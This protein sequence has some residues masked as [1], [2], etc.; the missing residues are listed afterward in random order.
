M[1]IPPIR[2]NHAFI[3]SALTN[4]QRLEVCNSLLIVHIQLKYLPRQ[5]VRTSPA[6]QFNWVQT[7]CVTCF[8]L[9]YISNTTF[10]D[11]VATVI[12]YV[13]LPGSNRIQINMESF[14]CMKKHGICY[15]F[16]CHNRTVQCWCLPAAQQQ[17]HVQHIVTIVK[18][19]MINITF[20]FIGLEWQETHV[21]R[22]ERLYGD[23]VENYRVEK[24]CMVCGSVTKSVRHELVAQYCNHY[25]I[26][27]CLI[28][29]SA[30]WEADVWVRALVRQKSQ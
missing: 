9:Q 13:S 7:S 1:F 8:T 23:C 11:T 17:Q 25:N 20:R 15:A 21:K 12:W 6:T 18:Y 26:C 27:V 16:Y 24:L 19:V 2:P 4:R 14:F 5:A 22:C 29:L 3:L 10:V 30:R 28:V